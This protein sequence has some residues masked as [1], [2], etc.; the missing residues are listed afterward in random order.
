MNTDLV[1]IIILGLLA[2]FSF[3]AFIIIYIPA[4]VKQIKSKPRACDL[5]TTLQEFQISSKPGYL[6][7]RLVYLGHFSTIKT[8]N[9]GND[10]SDKR[11]LC[12]FKKYAT[13]E[14]A[15]AIDEIGDFI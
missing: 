12:L 5:E 11:Q 14:I 15:K 8:G 7:V 6:F 4:I 3:I 1:V 13:D 10:F 2:I 9:H